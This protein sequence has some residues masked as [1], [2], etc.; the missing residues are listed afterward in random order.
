M[1]DYL[2]TDVRFDPAIPTP[3]SVLGF[4]VGEWHVRHDQLVAYMHRIAESSDRVRIETTGRTHE[5]RQLLILTVS[6]PAN[7]ERLEVLRQAHLQLSDPTTTDTL[8]TAD[9]PVVVNLGYSVHGN[10]ASG[11][12]ASL[13]TAYFLAAAQGEWIERL[14]RE[15]IVLIDP[16]LNPDGLARFAGWAN[17]HRGRVLVADPEHREHREGW[18]NGRT[19]HY[20]FDL[21]RDWLLAQHPETWARLEQFH[22]W[23]P[24][25][26]IDGHEM[27]SEQTYFFQPG[28]PIR[29]NPLT[30]ERNVT[31]TGEIA[32]YHAEALDAIGSLYYSE[33]TFDDFYYGKGSTYPDIHGAIGIL[34]EQASVRGHLRQT[35]HGEISFPFAI[36]NQF[37][38][39]LSTLRAAL[40]KR[41]ELLDYQRD[42]YTSAYRRAA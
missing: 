38:T 10:E 24:N 2:P 4:E 9:M 27:G 21:N 6:D 5:G 42:F 32:Q 23:R 37:Q 35:P 3:S 31:L 14:L 1:A 7:L 25:V 11:S 15:S 36:H 18:P 39:T 20:W 30:P 40:D 8:E 41:R 28:V 29:K 12:N 13:L 26:L 22:R 34:F 16:S 17:M 19:N 33:E